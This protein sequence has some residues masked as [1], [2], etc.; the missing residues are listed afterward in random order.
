M[1]CIFY[2]KKWIHK[3]V[4]DKYIDF[5]IIDD[6]DETFLKLRNY[7]KNIFNIDY[8]KNI[9]NLLYPLDYKRIDIIELSKEYGNLDMFSVLELLLK[10]DILWLSRISTSC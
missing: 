9:N 10:I 7:L 4:L 3:I 2:L 1:K 8:D 5:N 6:N